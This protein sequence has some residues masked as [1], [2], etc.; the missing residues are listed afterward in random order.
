MNIPPEHRNPR[1]SARE[2]V[3]DDFELA[4]K[5]TIEELQDELVDF[6]ELNKRNNIQNY[7]N[8]LMSNNFFFFSFKCGSL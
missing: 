4:F 2:E 3:L 7:K 8:N 5:D 6:S 1:F